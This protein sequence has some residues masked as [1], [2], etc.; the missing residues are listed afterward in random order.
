MS[1]GDFFILNGCDCDH[2]RPRFNKKIKW[3]D[4]SWES[5]EYFY[6]I[7]DDI[8]KRIE[9][10]FELTP[11][12]V[13]N[14]RADDFVNVENGS[15]DYCF[16]KY[17]NDKCFTDY[18]NEVDEVAWHHHHF[19]LIDGE[20]K[21]ETRDN[22]FLIEHIE[23]TFEAIKQYDVTTLHTGEL[24][25]NNDTYKTYNDGGF[26]GLLSYTGISI[27]AG[28]YN[29]CDYSRVIPNETYRPARDDYQMKDSKNITKLSVIPT[30]TSPSAILSSLGLI[31]Y[32]LRTRKINMSLF[33]NAAF[34]PVNA[35]PVLFKPFFRSFL[36]NYPDAKF[37]VSY[38]HSDELLPDKYKSKDAK[39]IYGQN[40]LHVNYRFMIEMLKQRERNPVFT[41]FKT[42][43]SLI[44]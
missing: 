28:E 37:F 18:H 1:K 30:T 24:F 27:E 2:D 19:R 22:V 41:N 15:Y 26:S 39:L 31:S 25:H 5:Y 33:N 21:S 38:F 35:S 36:N 17:F 23:R 4:T 6:R 13:L 9:D 7:F 3:G 14:I 29:L 10:E 34:V 32:F 44:N 11:S 20:W 12:L 8:R 42:L 16:K 43:S 40:N